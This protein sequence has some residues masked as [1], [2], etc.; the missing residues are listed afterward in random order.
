MNIFLKSVTFV[1]ILILFGCKDK[2]NSSDN[3]SILSYFPVQKELI[4]DIDNIP[5][6]KTKVPISLVSDLF[7]IVQNQC[8]VNYFNNRIYSYYPLSKKEFDK[9][10]ICT[11]LRSDTYEN[12]I[13]LISISKDSG[14]IVRKMKIYSS[15]YP[16][17]HS[18][19]ENNIISVKRSNTFECNDLTKSNCIKTY[20]E[21]FKLN[22]DLKHINRFVDNTPVLDPF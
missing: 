9:Y 16:K 18:T 4:V 13:F 14:S 17:V 21:K 2:D 5:F 3:S 11:I 6:N 10:W 7:G 1:L 19:I 12:S 20:V 8:E 15:L 22:N